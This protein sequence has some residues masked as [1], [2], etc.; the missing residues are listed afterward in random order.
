MCIRYQLWLYLF[1]NLQ[2]LRSSGIVNKSEVDLRVVNGAKVAT[3]TVGTYH[4]DLSSILVLEINDYYF[5]FI[6]F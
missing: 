1:F 4:L 5:Y 6:S 3:S 2:R